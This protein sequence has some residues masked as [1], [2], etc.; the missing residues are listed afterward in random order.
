MAT[1]FISDL[2]LGSAHPGI[3]ELFLQFLRNQARDSEA[4]YILGDLFEYWIGDDAVQDEYQPVIAG[5]RAL[6]DAGIP[7]YFMHGNRDVLIGGQFCVLTGG[8]LLADPTVIDLYGQ[9]TLLMHGDSLCTDDIKYQQFRALARDPAYQQA[10]LNK[11]IAERIA[12]VREAREKSAQHKISINEEIMDVN[13]QAVDTVMRQH[14]VTRL[15]HGH[16]HRPAV[17]QF[18]L[19][20]QTAT[21]IVLS[22][23]GSK[24]NYLIC[25]S[26]GCRLEYFT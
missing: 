22:D 21:R 25:D 5:L 11:T 15:I 3:A 18:A 4:L 12:F 8:K 17:H 10:F 20:G 2:H 9:P 16:T 23:W 14:Q 24:G 19:D 13:L 6:S 1:L 26:A 7:L